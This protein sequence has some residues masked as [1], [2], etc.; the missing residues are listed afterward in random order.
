ML[1]TYKLPHVTNNILG[2]IFMKS[3]KNANY[4]SIIN[5]ILQVK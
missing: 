5:Y 1:I 3:L 4:D 2:F